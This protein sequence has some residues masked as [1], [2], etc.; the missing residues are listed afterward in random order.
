[1]PPIPHPSVPSEDVYGS[2][3]DI[4][5]RTNDDYAI[6]EEFPDPRTLD[7]NQWQGWD[8]NDDFVMS[9]PNIPDISYRSSPWYQKGWVLPMLLVVVCF[10]VL[11]MRRY[12]SMK[13]RERL[14]YTEL[15]V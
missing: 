15:K 9:D 12:A 1:M 5:N 13:R 2:C 4:Y 3:L 14:G 8:A 7:W 11:Q 6:V 10:A